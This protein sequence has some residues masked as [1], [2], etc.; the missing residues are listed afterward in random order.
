MSVVELFLM[1]FITSELIRPVK[2]RTSK[3]EVC[4]SLL[5]AEVTKPIIADRQGRSPPAGA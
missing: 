3:V 5:H 4:A 1:D 2:P